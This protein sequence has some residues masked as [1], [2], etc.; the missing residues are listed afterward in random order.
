MQKIAIIV[1]QNEGKKME[2]MFTCIDSYL[3]DLEKEVMDIVA[4]STISLAEKNKLMEPIVDQKK[5][6]VYTKASLESIKNKK[7]EA[8]CGMSKI[9][10]Q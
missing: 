10:G 2:K 5:L 4:D 8:R 7:Y 9:D 6:L 3:K 1:P